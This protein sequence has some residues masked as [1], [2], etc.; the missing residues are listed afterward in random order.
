M[1]IR[2][3]FRGLMVFHKFADT[4]EIGFVDAP[5]HPATPPPTMHDAG[6]VP[7]ILTMKDGVITS[8]FDLRR[9]PELGTPVVRRWE[10][11]VMRPL[12]PTATTHENGAIFERLKHSDLMDF[13][14]VTDLE[15]KDLHDEDLSSK[16]DKTKL[17]FV[18]VVPHGHFYT[19]LLTE[20]QKKTSSIFGTPAKRFGCATEVMACDIAFNTGDA[21]LRV[22]GNIA[23]SFRPGFVY[24]FSNA[25][26]DVAYAIPPNKPYKDG[27]PSHFKMYYTHLFGT[28]P[29]EQFD[30]LPEID[31]D[32]APD[33]F[34]CGITSLGTSKNT[35]V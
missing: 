27:G 15:G 17:R 1:S 32:P 29:N 13:R 16:I 11:E 24:E 3:L 22:N 30:L 34:L 26:P 19:T 23:F 9:R 8:V 4:M 14:W 33:P 20:S 2:I 28:V 12:Q 31:P 35:L 7:R 6:H 5:G 10:I 18:L 25:P 21:N